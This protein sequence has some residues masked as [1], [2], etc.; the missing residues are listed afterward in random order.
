[1]VTNRRKF[2]VGLGAGIA[3]CTTDSKEEIGGTATSSDEPTDSDTPYPNDSESPTSAEPSGEAEIERLGSELTHHTTEYDDTAVVIAK[4][5]NASEYPSGQVEATA[6]FYDEEDSLL[7]TSTAY[8]W[9]L[10][11][12]E[13]WKAYIQYLG[14]GNEVARHEMDGKYQP[15]KPD[16]D[17][18]GI[19]LV[20]SSLNHEKSDYSESYYVTGKA[21]NNRS[22]TVS[23]LE[24]K[25]KFY[26]GED[27]VLSSN[28]TNITDVPPGDTWEFKVQTLSI[29][30][31][32]GEK[33]TDH[34]VAL[35]T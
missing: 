28:L 14:D 25:A 32:M 34:S 20:E 18:E 12:G 29:A 23:Y 27:V 35:S 4:L 2:L 5:K 3:G 22:T 19:A 31:E 10:D 33:V 30:V 11:S 26:L 9:S 17:D 16:L 7:E 24:A 6:R 15:R 13:T 21:K 1:M 8:L